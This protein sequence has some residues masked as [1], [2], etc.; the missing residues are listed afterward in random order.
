M[1]QLWGGATLAGIGFT[2]S[3]FVIELAFR[4]PAVRDEA[5][6]AVLVAA[7]VSTLLG[8]LLFR[9]QRL[10]VPGTD[11]SRPTVLGDTGRPG[12]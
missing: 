2:V 11:G 10:A 8:R 1:L 5:K 3:L 7:L 6:I 4:S 12:A 9:D